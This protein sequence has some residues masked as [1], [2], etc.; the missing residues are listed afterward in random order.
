MENV[1]NSYLEARIKVAYCSGTASSFWLYGGESSLGFGQPNRFFEIDMF[2]T[3]S[4]N[5]TQL[6]TNLH[7]GHT[8]ETSHYTDPK[9][10]VFRDQNGNDVNLADQ[11]LTYGIELTDSQIKMYV[12]N[13]QYA[14]YSF[15]PASYYKRPVPFNI[16]FGESASL[17]SGNP[18]NCGSLPKEMLVD[19]VRLYRKNTVEAIK[20]GANNGNITLC[21][22]GW[23]T[24]VQVD[25]YPGISYQW[26]STPFFNIESNPNGSIDC[27]CAR[28]WVSLQ[29]GTPPGDYTVPLAV[30]LPCGG[31]ETKILKIKVVDNS[32]PNT[33][34]KIYLVRG[35]GVYRPGVWKASNT[36]AYE[37]SSDGGQS[38]ET[39]QNLSQ[40]SYNIWTTHT[41]L[42]HLQPYYVNICV[43]ALNICGPSPTYCESVLVPSGECWWCPTGLLLPPT[44][45]VIE[46][47]LDSEKFQLKVQT[48]APADSYEWS[49]DQDYWNPVVNPS[50]GTIFYGY[51]YFGEFDVGTPPFLIYVRAK[52]EDTL[53]D[54]YAELIEIPESILPLSAASEPI[55]DLSIAH[56]V[57]L[58]D[59]A[60]NLEEK[61]TPL[62]SIYIFNVY[63]QLVKKG[64]NRENMIIELKEFFPAGLY[65]VLNQSERLSRSPAAKIAIIK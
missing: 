21:T 62:E 4:Q 7:Y 35:N 29:P 12:N 45:V 3:G 20:F 65:F 33:P 34:T 38:W 6:G 61:T 15:D 2:E 11:F 50:A 22:H 42:P 16:R 40:G 14:T 58:A 25:Y 31:T 18:S 52:Q 36:T 5:A 49:F 53:S 51:N 55:P 60:V 41:I 19:Y 28:W 46:R 44:D 37:W 32:T 64:T 39:V 1:P 27:N 54:V 8:Y 48:T 56:N 30:N 26:S 23:G 17:I 13:V 57:D 59:R 9:K 47:K 63:G 43:R 10:F 24:N